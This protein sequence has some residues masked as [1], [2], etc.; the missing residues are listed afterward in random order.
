MH[1]LICWSSRDQEKEEASEDVFDMVRLEAACPRLALAGLR[2]PSAASC[3]EAEECCCI[4]LGRLDEAPERGG[5]LLHL[6]GSP[7]RGPG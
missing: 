7:G 1:A 3:G 5:V 2:G 4:C 6:L